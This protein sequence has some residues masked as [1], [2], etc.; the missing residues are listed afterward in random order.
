MKKCNFYCWLDSVLRYIGNISASQITAARNKAI[1]Q[2][3]YRK[4]CKLYIQKNE[5]YR[6]SVK[7]TKKDRVYRKKSEIFRKSVNLTEKKFGPNI[8]LFTGTKNENLC[9]KNHR[10][11]NWEVPT[12]IANIR[13]HKHQIDQCIPSQIF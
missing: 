8:I 3:F 5:I 4:Q 11:L 7:C 1:L 12:I 9:L 2:Q 10:I 13:I 6:K